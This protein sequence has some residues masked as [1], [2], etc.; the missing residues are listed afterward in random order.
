MINGTEINFEDDGTAEDLGY[1]ILQLVSYLE[2]RIK[3]SPNP[4]AYEEIYDVLDGLMIE[5]EIGVANGKD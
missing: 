2:K 1:V 5:K 3:D 4:S